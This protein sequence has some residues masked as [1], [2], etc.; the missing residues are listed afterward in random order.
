[1]QSFSFS[2]TS[3]HALICEGEDVAC[4]QM[5]LPLA[6]SV[7]PPNCVS[8]LYGALKVQDDLIS[9]ILPL[10]QVVLIVVEATLGRHGR[11]MDAPFNGRLVAVSE[12]ASHH[13]AS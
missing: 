2:T 7:G 5:E 6:L 11:G 13:C 10:G 8:L 9:S 3:G 1:M 4:G 12:Y